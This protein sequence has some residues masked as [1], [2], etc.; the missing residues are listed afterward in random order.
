MSPVSHSGVSPNVI[1]GS[2]AA[3]GRWPWQ[4]SLQLYVPFLGGWY[5]ICGAVLIRG[6]VALTAAHCIDVLINYYDYRINI[7]TNDISAGD[8]QN[9]DI[10]QGIMGDSG[11]PFVCKSRSNGHTHGKGHASYENTHGNGHYTWKLLGVT[12]WGARGCPTYMP[13]VY[14]RV[15]YFYDWVVQTMN[16]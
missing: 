13:S 11:G 16:S 8:G 7:G 14:T 6:D 10:A 9:I 2:P 4:A 1:G 5:H 12:S 15:S 3:A